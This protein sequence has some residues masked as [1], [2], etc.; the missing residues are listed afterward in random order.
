MHV[1]ANTD[2][3]APTLA[4]TINMSL[5]S[6]ATFK[7]AVI[8][9]LLKKPN[10]YPDLGNN[11]RP[12]P[13]LSIVSTLLECHVAVQLRQHLDNNDLLDIFQSAHRQHNNTET[14]LVRFQNYHLKSVNRKKGVLTV[15][16][17]MSDVLTPLTTLLT[18][19]IHSTCIEG[20]PS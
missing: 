2:I 13:R 10:L 16:L 5:E 17:D 6:G 11:Y 14:A 1:K 9:T 8:T 12:I 15:P 18:G 19:Q 3:L 7:H 20:T 4:I